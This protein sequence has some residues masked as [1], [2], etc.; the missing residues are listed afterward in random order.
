MIH[1]HPVL[2][3]Q[4]LFY[5]SVTFLKKSH[6]SNTKFQYKTV[7]SLGVRGLTSSTDLWKK[8]IYIHISMQYTYMSI[9][10]IYLF[11][12]HCI[13]YGSFWQDCGSLATRT[14]HFRSLAFHVIK[15]CST[16][17]NSLSIIMNCMYTNKST[18]KSDSNSM[19]YVNNSFTFFSRLLITSNIS[20]VPIVFHQFFTQIALGDVDLCFSLMLVTDANAVEEQTKWATWF[21]RQHNQ[22]MHMT[23]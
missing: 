4:V 13:L 3:R 15:T 22:S 8:Y 18:N 5:T 7:Y 14:L 16:F 1:N 23:A 17:F 10:Y 6:K 11:L 19:S 20:S 21:Y 12:I 2:Y 9:Q